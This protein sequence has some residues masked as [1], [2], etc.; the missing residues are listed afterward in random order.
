MDKVWFYQSRNGNDRVYSGDSV[1]FAKARYEQDKDNGYTAEEIIAE[2]YGHVEGSEEDGHF[3]IYDGG[4][5][6]L[7]EVE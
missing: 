7:Y 1:G 4:S 2:G 3:R 6:V 5:I